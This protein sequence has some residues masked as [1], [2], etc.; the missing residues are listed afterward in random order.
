MDPHPKFGLNAAHTPRRHNNFITLKNLITHII[1]V[2]GKRAG[3]ASQAGPKWI[4]RA[5]KGSWPGLLSWLG[6][7][8]R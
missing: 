6:G 3:Q 7:G 4:E 1:D 5:R 2:S 8:A